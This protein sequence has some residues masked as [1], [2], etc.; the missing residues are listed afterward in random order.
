MDKKKQPNTDFKG[1]VSLD[2]I[3]AATS[4]PSVDGVAITIQED[5]SK[6]KPKAEEEAKPATP[7]KEEVEEIKEVEATV[8]EAKVQHVPSSAYD[9]ALRLISL[10][11]LKDFEI[12]VGEEDEGTLISEFKNMTED[13][14]KEIL[15]FQDQDKKDDISSNYISKEGLEEHELK[16]IEILKNGGDLSKIAETEEQAFSRPFEGFDMEDEKRQIDVLYTDFVHEKGIKK[17]TAI[18]IIQELRKEGKLEK[19]AKEVFD[20]YRKTASEY[21]DSILEQQKKDKNFKETNF[22]ENKKTLR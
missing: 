17:D 1:A 3:L 12:S 18:K 16:V 15:E 10:G 20:A 22:K 14:L 4:K 8:E 6:D 21:I 13:N 11:I 2:T 19:E 5:L 9:T 7:I